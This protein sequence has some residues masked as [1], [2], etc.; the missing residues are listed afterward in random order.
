MERDYT[1]M[2]NIYV[3]NKGALQLRSVPGGADD[4]F[5]PSPFYLF[6]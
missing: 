2:I 4:K 1:L 5:K 6:Q 3:A